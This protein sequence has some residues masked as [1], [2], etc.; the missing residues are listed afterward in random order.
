MVDAGAPRAA[1]PVIV[2]PTPIAVRVVRAAAQ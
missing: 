1:A 2:I